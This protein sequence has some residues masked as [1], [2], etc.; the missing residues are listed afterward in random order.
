L[1][2]V[3]QF[4]ALDLSIVAVIV[5]GVLLTEFLKIENARPMI[6]LAIVATVVALILTLVVALANDIAM[7]RA[8]QGASLLVG[9]WAG[10]ILFWLVWWFR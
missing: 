2:N 10:V 7:M 4:L 8:F 3:L 5:A 6:V 1:T 9:A